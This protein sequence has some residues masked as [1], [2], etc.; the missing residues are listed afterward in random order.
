[1]MLSLYLVKTFPFQAKKVSGVIKQLK[2]A[3]H[4]FNWWLQF[5]GI[6][7]I[8]K[9]LLFHDVKFKRHRGT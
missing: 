7:D 6:Q 4:F 1:M 2:Y 9:A 5:V 3:R 8:L